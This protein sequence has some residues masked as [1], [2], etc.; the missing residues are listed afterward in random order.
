MMGILSTWQWVYR[1]LTLVSA[2]RGLYATGSSITLVLECPITLIRLVRR[3][4]DRPWRKTFILF[5]WV[6]VTVTC[7]LAMA[8]TVSDINGAW[9][10]RPW[11]SWA[12]ALILSGMMLDL[13]GSNRMLLHAR[14]R[15]VNPLGTVIC[16]GHLLF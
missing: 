2:A 13:V 16:L 6:T 12:A 15:H 9:T 5:R 10:I 1:V 14:L 3:L 4:T 11:A 8:L 7:V